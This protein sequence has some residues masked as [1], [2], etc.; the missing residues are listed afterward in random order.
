MNKK[1]EI[2]IS[3]EGTERARKSECTNNGFQV[4][5]RHGR[6]SRGLLRETREETGRENMGFSLF[7]SKSPFVR[8]IYNES[9]RCGPMVPDRLLDFQPDAVPI[10]G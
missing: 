1:S 4:R 6:L 10:F 5:K 9:D 2:S 8:W 3:M 7:Q